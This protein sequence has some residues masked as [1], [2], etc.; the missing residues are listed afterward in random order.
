MEFLSGS[1]KPMKKCCEEAGSSTVVVKAN[2]N[3]IVRQSVI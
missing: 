3:S 2:L 1:T